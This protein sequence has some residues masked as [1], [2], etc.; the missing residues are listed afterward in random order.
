[1]SDSTLSVDELRSRIGAV[2]VAPGEGS[3]AGYISY[4]TEFALGSIEIAFGDDRAIYDESAFP[5]VVYPSESLAATIVVSGDGTIAVVDA[6]DPDHARE[7]LAD[8]METLVE[9]GLVADDTPSE[10]VLP[11]EDVPFTLDP[12]EV[13]TLGYDD[14]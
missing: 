6:T 10:T 8:A 12:P 2:G 14:E 4:D 11:A 5:G 3:T 1:M 7:A 9:L 13:E